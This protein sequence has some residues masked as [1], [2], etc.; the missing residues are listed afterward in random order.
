MS[1]SRKTLVV[2]YGLTAVVGLV[3]TWI[4]NATYL[5]LGFVP[6]YVQFWRETLTTP[7]SASVTIDLICVAF[8][9]VLWMLLEARR[10]GLRYVWLY[11]LAGFVVALSVAVALFLLQRERVLATRNED[12]GPGLTSA[13]ILG[14]VA[15]TAVSLA[16]IGWTFIH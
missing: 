4:H 14:V 1:P 15:L 7:A 3:A 10:I 16:Y 2:I 8:A 12:R 11:V 9:I 5:H 13:D 6:A